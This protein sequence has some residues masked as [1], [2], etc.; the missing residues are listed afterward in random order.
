[1]ITL[2]AKKLISLD[3]FTTQYQKMSFAKVRVEIDSL[4]SL[5]PRILIQGGR[6]DFLATTYV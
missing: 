2:E 4:E 6:R 3:D 5:K 1:M